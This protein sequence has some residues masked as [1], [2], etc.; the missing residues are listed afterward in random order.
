MHTD[1]DHH[2]PTH[3]SST[4]SS[5]CCNPGTIAPLHAPTGVSPQTQTTFS[6]SQLPSVIPSVSTIAASSKIHIHSSSFFEVCTNV[7]KHKINH[8]E[9]DISQ[10]DSDNELFKKIWERYN[11]SRGVGL[12]RLF[13]RP[14]NVH[15]V[16]V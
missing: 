2:I 16:E 10:V 3:E 8:H 6:V 12:R 4:D 14:S 11:T 5:R 15:F 7:G 13:L 9:I 1:S